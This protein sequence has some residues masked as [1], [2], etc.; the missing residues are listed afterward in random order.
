MAIQ[1]SLARAE[2]LSAELLRATT[3]V[4]EH[5]YAAAAAVDLTVQEA[6]LLYIVSL[7]PS[8]MLGLTAALDVPKS[9]MSGLMTRMESAGLIVREPDPQDRRHLLASPT[10]RGIEIARTFGGDLA[11][12]VEAVLS[13]LDPDERRELAGILTGIL[14]TIER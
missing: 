3:T 1:K 11:G 6:R 5:Y 14:S 4:G 12:R 13:A 7:Q 10:P 2:P 8:N 9:T